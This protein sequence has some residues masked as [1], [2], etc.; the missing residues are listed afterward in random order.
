MGRAEPPRTMKCRRVPMPLPA[1][2]IDRR[3]TPGV[4]RVV[5]LRLVG[6]RL[7]AV[8]YLTTLQYRFLAS[9]LCSRATPGTLLARACMHLNGDRPKDG[10]NE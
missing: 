5:W 6:P 10:T 3:H 9:T 1:V 4:A 7:L 2:D 8:S